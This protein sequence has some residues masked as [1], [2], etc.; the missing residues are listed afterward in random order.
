MEA[1]QKAFL[2]YGDGHFDIMNAGDHVECAVTGR[3][4]HL[5]QLLYWSS[6]R[7]EAYVSADIAL[8]RAKDAPPEY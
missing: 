4:I 2:Y 1:G 6:D 3:K 8:G 7:Q 5:N